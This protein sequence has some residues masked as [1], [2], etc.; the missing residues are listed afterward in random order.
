MTWA[1]NASIAAAPDSVLR[2]RLNRS[3]SQITHGE[4]GRMP[5]RDN[6]Q[7]DLADVA[8]PDGGRQQQRQQHR[9][10]ARPTTS[11]CARGV[12]VTDAYEPR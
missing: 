5:F 2:K 4:A 12:Q 11:G 1:T 10:I 8:G 6:E 3:A 7:G 9:R